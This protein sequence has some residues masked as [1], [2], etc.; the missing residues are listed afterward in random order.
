[1]TNG[2]VERVFSHLR[3]VIPGAFNGRYDV[4]KWI[5]LYEMLYGPQ[6]ENEQDEC[7]ILRRDLEVSLCYELLPIYH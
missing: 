3:L 4:E 1:M 7:D 6:W 5:M 2:K